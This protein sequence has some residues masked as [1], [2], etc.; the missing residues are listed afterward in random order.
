[1]SVQCCISYRFYM[2][3]NTGLKWVNIYQFPTDVHIN[4][5]IFQGL[6][7][8]IFARTIVHEKNLIYF[9]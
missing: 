1:M 5:N 3:C 4:F 2:K 8:I 6:K 7:R 9:F